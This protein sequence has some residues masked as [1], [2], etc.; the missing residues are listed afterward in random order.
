M[1]P[2]PIHPPAAGQGLGAALRAYRRD[3]S[4]SQAQLGELVGL[5]QSY[6]SLLER[7]R[8]QVHDIATLE[9]VAGHIGWNAA[10]PATLERP[11]DWSVELGWSV[12]RLGDAA[13]ASGR[14]LLAV[15]ELWPLVQRLHAAT[16]SRRVEGATTRLAASATLSFATAL[17]H[18]LTQERLGLAI[19]WCDRA[20]DLAAQLDDDRLRTH[21]LRT[22]GNE[23]RK[24]GRVHDALLAL[25]RSRALASHPAD[26]GTAAALL[27]RSAAEAGDATLFQE[28]LRDAYRLLDSGHF[29]SAFHPYALDE[30]QLRGLVRLHRLQQAR[31]LLRRDP[32]V[33]G[34]WVTPQWR[35]LRLITEAHAALA[36]QDTD[37]MAD[38][39]STALRMAEQQHLSR[40][41]QRILHVVALAPSGDARV[42]L[43]D[44]SRAALARLEEPAAL[45]A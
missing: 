31:E 9:R 44:Q 38:L 30:I 37:R 14:P 42:R 21:A 39:V 20:L 29:T 26:R 45:P 35:V 24:A 8:R 4:L 34:G 1:Q 33:V 36:L 32:A 11:L 25:R 40:Q 16:N 28:A 17:G 19:D 23:L 27:A 12:V 18:V 7:G 3:H 15:R 41:I 13:R 6:I 2:H 22:K 43:R 10:P 5:H